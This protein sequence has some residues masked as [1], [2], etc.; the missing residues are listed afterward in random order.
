[1]S[2]NGRGAPRTRTTFAASQRPPFSPHQA[3]NTPSG[4]H[5]FTTWKTRQA[6]RPPATLA[7]RRTSFDAQTRRPASSTLSDRRAPQRPT[8]ESAARHTAWSCG[9][10]GG[11][12]TTC[13][14]EAA[15]FVES[16]SEGHAPGR[17]GSSAIQ[18]GRND[19]P[20][21]QRRFG[22]RPT[23]PAVTT[24]G[25]DFCRFGRIGAASRAR[26]LGEA[27][28]DGGLA[29][30]RASQMTRRLP[31]RQFSHSSAPSPPAASHSRDSQGAHQQLVGSRCIRDPGVVRIPMRDLW[32]K[33]SPRPCCRCFG[34]ARRGPRCSAA[35]RRTTRVEDP[36]RL[37]SS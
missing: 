9:R 22:A 5:S 34:R 3:Q 35:T 13:E 6:V 11:V 26:R 28:P 31:P 17:A 37:M 10:S 8:S 24:L 30:P 29:G 2:P 27:G 33:R 14:H 19:A 20:N 21:A 4:G 1:M 25:G 36:W 16:L 23:R 15:P 32:P 18:V 7:L 12:A